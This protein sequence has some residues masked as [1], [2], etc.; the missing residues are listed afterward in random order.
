MSFAE[1]WKQMILARWAGEYPPYNRSKRLAV[2]ST[3]EEAEP[4]LKSSE[5]IAFDLRGAG[6]FTSDEVSEFMMASG[7]E[8]AFDDEGKPKWK[9]EY[10]D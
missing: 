9:I 2:A 10:R 4:L 6:D 3:E 5:D 7:Y 1:N 8:I